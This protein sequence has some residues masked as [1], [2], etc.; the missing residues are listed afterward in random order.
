MIRAA[1][2]PEVYERIR[3]GDLAQRGRRIAELIEAARPEAPEDI[4]RLTARNIQ[5]HVVATTWFYYRFRFGLSA[6]DTVSAATL[7]IATAILGLPPEPAE[8]ERHDG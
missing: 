4:K 6:A 2:P 3:T 7:A 8:G 5:Y 1:L